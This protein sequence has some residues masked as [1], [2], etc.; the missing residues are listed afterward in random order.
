M[1]K[2][3][4]LKAMEQLTSSD[5]VAVLRGLELAGEAHRMEDG[6]LVFSEDENYYAFATA[7]YLQDMACR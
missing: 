5:P 2:E 3:M 1:A 4:M 6:M 7:T